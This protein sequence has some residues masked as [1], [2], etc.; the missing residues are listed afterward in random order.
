MP[1][2]LNIVA[3]LYREP[4]AVFALKEIV[5]GGKLKNLNAPMVLVALVCG[6]P[7]SLPDHLV[8]VR[9]P[10][11][12]M[13]EE[14]PLERVRA[15]MI[16]KKIVEVVGIRGIERILPGLTDE[17]ERWFVEVLFEGDT[18]PLVRE[19]GVVSLRKKSEN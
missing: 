15:Y 7:E 3:S 6:E 5:R 8:L 16:V 17:G 1:Y 2:A 18:A 4:R 9:T 10:I 12:L 19:N 14:H 11:A 13:H